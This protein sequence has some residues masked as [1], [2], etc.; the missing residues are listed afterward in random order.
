MKVAGWPLLRWNDGRQLRDFIPRFLWRGLEICVVL[1]VS[2]TLKFYE[3]VR[4]H[5]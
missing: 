4:Y 2:F 5:F 1:W 3:K